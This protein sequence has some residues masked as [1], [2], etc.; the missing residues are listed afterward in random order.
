MNIWTDGDSGCDGECT[1]ADRWPWMYR[2][3]VLTTVAASAG[4][5]Y[6]NL[7]GV[8]NNLKDEGQFAS[9]IT[10]IRTAA[11]SVH[12]DI[13]SAANESKLDDGL[14]IE[15]LSCSIGVCTIDDVLRAQQ[16][17]K[18]AQA[19]YGD[20]TPA[21]KATLPA[22]LGVEPDWPDAGPLPQNFDQLLA[23]YHPVLDAIARRAR[24]VNKQEAGAQTSSGGMST[25]NLA[26]LAFGAYLLLKK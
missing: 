13:V 11:A 9:D 2:A 15:R 5:D 16:Q 17:Y 24:G 3:Q 8:L 12:L 14:G 4:V 25:T 1:A 23:T 20:L 6:S 7:Q 22:S 26:L 18:V 21:T 10:K 19:L